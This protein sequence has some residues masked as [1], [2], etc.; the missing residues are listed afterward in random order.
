[1]ALCCQR[2]IQVYKPIGL[3]E[4]FLDEDFDEFELFE[5]A[6]SP[7]QVFS[8]VIR[9]GKINGSVV[10]TM[11]RAEPPTTSTFVKSLEQIENLIIGRLK[12][13]T[14]KMSIWDLLL[15]S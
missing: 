6:N 14:I 9:G 7:T 11:L 8:P 2:T 3:R 1:M 15:G 10:P 12:A 5:I 13:T 4:K